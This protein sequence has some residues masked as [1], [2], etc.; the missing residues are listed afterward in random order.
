MALRKVHIDD[1]Y[2]LGV[3]SVYV[4]GSQAVIRM[5]MMQHQLDRRNGLNTAGLISGY[6]GSPIGGLDLELFRIRQR[7]DRH[8]LVFQPGLNEDLAATALWGAQQAELR[9]EGRYDG[10]FGLWYGKGPGVDRSGDVFRHANHAGTSPHGGIV[11]LMGDDHTCE[12][13]TSAHQSEFAF[14]D[15]MIPV[16]NPAGVQEII[17]FGLFGWALSRYAGVWTGLKCVKD[18]IEQTASV[19]AGLDRYNFAVPGDFEMPE[20]GINIRLGDQALAKEARLHDHKRPAVLAFARANGI[21]RMIFRG[22]KTAKIGVVTTGKSYMDVAEAFDL[23]GIDEVKAA[24]LGIRLYK[25]GMTWPLEPEGISRFADGLDLIIVVE[26]KRSLVETQIKEQLYGRRN[27]PMVIGKRDEARNWL[28]PAKG[29]LEP[30]M[31]ARVLATRIAAYATDDQI[32]SRVRDLQASMPDGHAARRLAERIPYFCAGCPHNSS[33][34]G[35]AGSRAYAGIGCHY[36]A[37]WMDRETEG[38]THMGAEGANWIGEAPF[39]KRSHVFQNLGDGTY[40]HS[41]SLAIRAAVAA[42]TNITYK[43]LYNDAVAMTGGQ[44]LDGGITVPQIARQVAAEG[45][46]RIAIVS[47]EPGKYPSNAGFPTG[48]SI[49]HRDD[50]QSVQ[51]DLRDVPGASVLIYDQTCAAEKRRRRKRGLYPDP[52]KRV[53]INELVCEGCGDCGVQ[54]N[55]VAIVPVET[56]F[57]RKRAIDQ[58]A[59]NKDYSC[60]KGFCPSFVT[61]HGGELKKGAG[62]D[63]AGLG[64]TSIPAL[65]EPELPQ[66]D[67]TF[68]M[69]VTGVGGT[70]V[71]TL[72][73]IIGM[74]GHLEGKGVGVID[75]AGLAQKGGAVS[76][77]IRMG[78]RP[79]DIKAIRASADGAHL[80]LGGDLVVAASDKVLQ[81]T[82]AEKTK[83]V[84][85]SHEIMTADF[86]R[87][88]DKVLPM[89]EMMDALGERAGEANC[90]FVDAHRYALALFGDSVSAN[91]FLLGY[92]Y[93]IGGLPVTS[94]SL[95]EAIRLNGVA[96][97][98]NIQAF[99]AG[100]LAAHDKAAFDELVKPAGRQPSGRGPAQSLDDLVAR[101]VAFL[102]DYQDA[103]Y[104]ERYRDRVDEIRALEAGL[105]PDS[106]ALS[107]AVARAYFKLLGYKDE[108]EVARLYTNGAF[109]EQLGR[110]FKEGYRLEF[111]MAPPLLARRD[112]VTGVPRK[113]R[114]G[115]WMMSVFRV[116]AKCKGLRGT[117]F[118]PFGYSDERTFERQLIADYEDLLETIRLHL[119]PETYMVAVELAS[120]PLSIRGYGHVKR[121]NAR[122][123]AERRSDLMRHL[124]EG[125]PEQRIAAE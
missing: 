15:A 91:L 84:V 109:Q 63:R 106:E 70:G 124:K 86:T 31:I 57:G 87:R 73:A 61:V 40:T 56:E 38:F 10:V 53:V 67:G 95:S 20:G 77:H 21:D 32:S 68:S 18:N 76:V 49:H 96:V 50:I 54:S 65:P 99:R 64:A 98:K 103:G 47:D 66:L 108:Y 105:R 88:P 26:E 123:A 22:G 24:N 41:G 30:V 82:R 92:A 39:S 25:A 117:A 118:D 122:A 45:V 17:D 110:E 9:G 94:A 7:L 74:A 116:L 44:R 29:A 14:V 102:T 23:L 11:A 81:V 79:E 43:I 36:M 3:E 42:G 69:V 80:V 107:E 37:Q 59:C 19:N 62:Q 120:L 52:P 16:L 71:V 58:S 111:H 83:L 85:N 125:K 75:M 100:R 101:R 46:K 51:L 34:V 93:Q 27:A 112:K 78:A 1:K 33:T 2:D 5:C 121:R 89:H 35:P 13:S 119:K 97:E 28:F 55:C 72:G 60:L 114:F 8:N 4:S 90:H 113:M 12:S 48:V 104:A 115:P 6:R